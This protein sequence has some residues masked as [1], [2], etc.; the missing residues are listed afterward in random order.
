[1]NLVIFGPPG[2]G[3]GTQAKRIADK[4]NYKQVSTGDL[5][6]NEIE[7]NSKIGLKISEIINKGNFVTDDLVNSLIEKFVSNTEY[8]NRII[9]DGYPRNVNQAQNLENLLKK[10]NQKLSVVLYLNVSR[11]TIEKRIKGRVTCEKCN[12]T[13]NEFFNEREILDHKCGKSHFKKRT[14][15]NFDTIIKRY[16][17]YMKS[18]KPVID[19][20]LKNNVLKEID[21]SLK[22]DEIA[23]KIEQILHVYQVDFKQSSY[24]KG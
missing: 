4:Y 10:N 2:A 18:T 13:L 12:V 22:I 23:S 21:G 11:D 19:Y 17:I 7:S 6:R 5:L 20:Y 14:D 8:K 9:F 16:E 3:K 24:I 15:D 1:M